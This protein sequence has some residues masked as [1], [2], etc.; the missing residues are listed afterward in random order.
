MTETLIPE[1]DKDQEK[2]LRSIRP[3]KIILPTIIGL[4][5]IVYL[6]LSQLDFEE[7]KRIN[8]TT[9]TFFWILISIAVYLL[10][11]VF[12][13]WRLKILSEDDFGWWKSAELV[14][15]LEF[16]TAVS[17]TNFGGSAVAFFLLIQEHIS[18]A[19][20]TAIVIYTI[21]A[22]TLFFMFSMP[23]LYFVFG[24]NIFI[25]SSDEFV[26]WRGIGATLITVWVI[27]TIYGM[28][29]LW[30]LFIQPVHLKKFLYF[31]AKWKIFGK[32]R[33]RIKSAGDDI[34]QS[35]NRI[36]YKPASFHYKATIAT[37]CSWI[38]RF[39]SITAIL[40]ALSPGMPQS[41]YDHIILFGRG[42]AL[43]AVTYYSPTPGGS[44]VA[45]IIFYQFYSEYI[46]RGISLLAA[47]LWR[48]ITYY[49]YLIIGAI[50]IPIWIRKILIRRKKKINENLD[51]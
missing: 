19:R 20:S 42:E 29:L 7:F 18:G 51:E 44:G 36:R 43:Y 5:V 32:T 33:H 14:T 15:I 41:I 25:P 8:W 10:R 3:S 21:V 31:L 2:V 12:L 46:S 6:G 38:C 48:T 11:H 45:E 22:D 40:I 34:E 50:I 47:V 13:S 39:F 35:S 16:A 24:E 1:F 30:G 9:T 4:A 37:I 23:I 28:L 17:P 26:V 27:M 49:P